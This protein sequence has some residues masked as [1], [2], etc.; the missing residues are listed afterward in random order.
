MM[1]LCSSTNFDRWKQTQGTKPI[2]DGSPKK[3]LREANT[4][5]VAL[6]ERETSETMSLVGYATPNDGMDIWKHY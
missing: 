3:K 4:Y 5:Q 6:V 1:S 2:L